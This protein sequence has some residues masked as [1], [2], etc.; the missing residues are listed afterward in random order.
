MSLSGAVRA[1]DDIDLG[2]KI[3]AQVAEGREVFQ[4]KVLDH[5]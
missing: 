5:I 3:D 2:R 4:F 1:N